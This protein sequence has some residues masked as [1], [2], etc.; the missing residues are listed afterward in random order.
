M[1][2]VNIPI[3]SYP[4]FKL[5]SSLIDKDPVIFQYIL[6]DYIKL[7]EYL[8][9][10][11]NDPN[12]Q[13]S[14]KSEQQLTLF[15]KSYLFETSQ[16]S[17]KIFTLGSINPDIL[18]NSKSLKL[19]VFKFIKLSKFDGFKHDGFTV[20]NFIKI[21]I[22]LAY[23]NLNINQSLI[24][25][26]LIKGYF[27][28][29]SIQDYL[30]TLISET[31]FTN[32]D[33]DTLSLFLNKNENFVNEYW[34]NVLEK[35]YNKGESI[36]TKQCFQIM[37]ISIT[38]QSNKQLIR[39]IKSL[40][41]SKKQMIEKYQLLS[42][43]IFSRKFHDMKP[44]LLDDLGFNTS[45]NVNKLIELFPTLT[46]N[47]AKRLLIE[48]NN[49]IELITNKLFENPNMETIV[50]FGK[51][52][53]SDLNSIS[54][55]EELKQKTLSNALRLLYESDEDEPDDTYD[56]T[57]T[58]SPLNNEIELK[59]FEIYKTNP[60]LLSRQSRYSTF[61]NKLKSEI[62]WTDEQIEGWFIILLKN[63]KR[64][65]M[66]NES[67]VIDNSLNT[68]GMKVKE[69]N[70]KP[71]PS[72]VVNNNNNNNKVKKGKFANHNRKLQHDKKMVNL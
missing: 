8:I 47:K 72:K 25:T 41:G 61:R 13:L 6:K 55:N 45:S 27:H 9:I 12:L 70:T 34:I 42:K 40:A 19:I 2:E 63:P 71:Q 66:L 67:L 37:L 58:T 15:L 32:A 36:H 38:S 65:K 48:Y 3:V 30:N 28:Y 29:R 54:S 10:I 51:K 33:L 18:A 62:K 59:L 43:I 60:D 35:L 57:T 56:T 53:P 50:Q 24:S 4:P 1:T 64:L 5:R 17:T 52:K 46:I 26:D 7:F 11:Y 22:K 20:W 23:D 21:Y 69:K 39:L 16:E 31:K 49:N 68:K 14:C 44:N